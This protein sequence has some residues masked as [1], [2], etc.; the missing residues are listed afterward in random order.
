MSLSG[1][2][3]LALFKQLYQLKQFRAAATLLS[4]ATNIKE[5]K[6]IYELITKTIQT[7]CWQSF[8][9]NPHLNPFIYHDELCEMLERL[10]KA[11]VRELKS[12]QLTD[13]DRAQHVVRNLQ[14][15]VVLIAKNPQWCRV[16]SYSYF[17]PLISTNPFLA[18]YVTTDPNF[19]VHLDS[20]QIAKILA[21]EPFKA[22]NLLLRI[23]S[24][25]FNDEEN[26]HWAED[27]LRYLLVRNLEAQSMMLEKVQFHD[28]LEIT[29]LYFEENR[30][31]AMEVLKNKLLCREW[32][33]C[34][35]AY[36]H[37][38]LTAQDYIALSK[39]HANDPGLSAQ[40][41]RLSTQ[42][43][44]N[45]IENMQMLTL[46]ESTEAELLTPANTMIV[47]M[48]PVVNA[49]KQKEPLQVNKGD[50]KEGPAILR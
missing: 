28:F 4:H 39:W 13:F 24:L 40:Y 47:E 32:L 29:F 34:N 31:F 35:E 22:R 46:S 19:F 36:K 38:L 37:P 27:T 23:N 41:V 2:F 3:S 9:S 10:L 12:A 42:S 49:E 7:N 1:P 11:M 15:T 17:V 45:V 6:E 50:K 5:A 26:A 33:K 16:L 18:H 14:Q 48:K 43:M 25:I 8:L 44:K 30:A 21:L 20:V